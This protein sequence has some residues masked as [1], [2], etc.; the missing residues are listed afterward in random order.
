MAEEWVNV[1]GNWMNSRAKQKQ[2]NRDKDSSLVTEFDYDCIE[3]SIGHAK[4]SENAYPYSL[5]KQSWKMLP[6]ATEPYP[7]YQLF[8]LSRD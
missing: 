7:D 2:M 6:M 5:A 4:C 3:E 8:H 1:S